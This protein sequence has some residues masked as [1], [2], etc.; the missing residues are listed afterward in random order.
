MVKFRQA[1]LSHGQIN[2]GQLKV[3]HGQIRISHLYVIHMV[4]L[5]WAILR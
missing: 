3:R 4:K 1:I 2:V 5:G